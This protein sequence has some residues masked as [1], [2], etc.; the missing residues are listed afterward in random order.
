MKQRRFIFF[1]MLFQSYSSKNDHGEE[2]KI[3]ASAVIGIR[4]LK[5]GTA[6]NAQI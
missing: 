4:H 3:M 5:H 6:I 2:K 1:Q